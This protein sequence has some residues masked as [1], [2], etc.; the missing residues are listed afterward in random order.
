MPQVITD[1]VVEAFAIV[2]P[3]NQVPEA[4]N[5]RM[6]DVVDRVS[7]ISRTHHPELVAACRGER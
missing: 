1:E 4:L 6:G 7:F 3:V 5:R 2:A